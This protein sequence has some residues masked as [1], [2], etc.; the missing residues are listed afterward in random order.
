MA[1]ARL[2]A[3][4]GRLLSSQRGRD[5]KLLTRAT[6]AIVKLKPSLIVTSPLGEA[7]A[8]L[9]P[10]HSQVG[11]NEVPPLSWSLPADSD[12]LP[13]IKSFLLVVEDPDAPLPSPVVHGIYYNIPPTKT[14]IDNADFAPVE[15][16]GNLLSGGFYYG[17]NRRKIIWGGPKPVL[18]HGV[19]RYFF[20]VLALSE[21]LKTGSSIGKEEL[22]QLLEGKVLAW[23]E[24]LGTISLESQE[25]FRILLTRRREYRAGSD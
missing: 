12:L 21:E 5:A 4:I 18:G 19:H 16:K 13:Q 25:H 23:G 7:P 2:E 8:P 22:G 1:A 9:L 24:W 6:P 15:G 10:A 11:A 20:Q 3:F 17:V 14:S